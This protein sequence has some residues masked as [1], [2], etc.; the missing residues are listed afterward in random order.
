MDLSRRDVLRV[1]LA[2]S[3][4]L[5][6]GAFAYGAAYE[7]R[8]LAC[9]QQ[10]VAVPGLPAA[11][12]GLRIGLISD[13]HHSP[14]VSVDH[15][16]EA[17]ALLAAAR[18]DLVVLGGDY[19]S[20]GNH[21]YVE[22]VAELL[23]PLATAPL[24]AVAVIGN[25]DRERDTAPALTRRG[26]AVIRDEHVPL[27]IKGTTINLLGL[28]YW[29]RSIDHIAPLVSQA[30]PHCILLAHDPRRLAQA[31]QLG[32]PLVLSGHTHGGQVVLPGLA[33]LVQK[34]FPTLAGVLRRDRTTLFVTRGVG[35]VYLPVRFNCP[36]EVAVVTLRTTGSV[37]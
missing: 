17:V 25:H 16:S 28:R 23:T 19:V 5:A 20:L 11:I 31:S 22:P 37:V 6:T 33:R 24:G 35:T 2:S 26:F 36:P 4:G 30:G 12:D 21:A 32:V 10:D 34:D 9:V 27:Q 1:L 3:G 7:R 13:V 15:V 18:P 8:Q 14:T 29:T